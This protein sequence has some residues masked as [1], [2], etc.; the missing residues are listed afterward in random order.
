MIILPET[1]GMAMTNC[2]VI[3][4]EA[5]KEAVLFHAPDHTGLTAA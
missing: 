2:F 1:G 4:D 5:T 3:A